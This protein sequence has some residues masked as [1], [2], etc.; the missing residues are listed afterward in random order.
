MVLL[1]ILLLAI[2]ITLAA[3]KLHA[4]YFVS[5]VMVVGLSLRAITRA[6]NA[7]DP[8][9]PSLL[10]QAIREQLSDT[11]MDRPK[12][13]LGTYGSTALADQALAYCQQH[14]AA[15]VVCFVRELSLN[16]RGFT[17]QGAS[18]STPTRW[19]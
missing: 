8:N 1:G 9:K 16:E 11:S 5:G 13:L 10:R 2:W 17:E 15:L 12:V 7:R 14:R 6:V 4:L 18:R 3:T 19:R